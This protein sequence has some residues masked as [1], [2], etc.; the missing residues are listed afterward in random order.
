[1]HG[2]QAGQL[3][4]GIPS[5]VTPR[6]D[7]TKLNTAKIVMVICRLSGGCTPSLATNVYV[8]VTVGLTVVEP[9]AATE[10]ESSVTTAK[11][12]V[13]ASRIAVP[14]AT[15]PGGVAVKVLMRAC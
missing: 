14:G 9:F 15:G 11:L 7:R 8:V 12:V 3:L 13:H 1:M 5:T 6:L 10:T 2:Q 4:A